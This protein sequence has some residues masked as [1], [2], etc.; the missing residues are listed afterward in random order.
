MIRK[1]GNKTNPI[2]YT[3]SVAL[4][5]FVLY[6]VYFNVVFFLFAIVVISCV[7]TRSSK[8]L[9]F[10]SL[11]FLCF[12]ILYFIWYLYI[13]FVALSR[14]YAVFP[15]DF[16][17][18][19]HV[20]VFSTHILLSLELFST[21]SFPHCVRIVGRYYLSFALVYYKIDAI[22]HKYGFIVF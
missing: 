6:S 12:F 14:L 10:A 17:V 21:V 9:F 15:L 1:K 11:R 7:L 20:P 3:K 13:W 2:H 19:M 8:K 18:F 5:V 22:I 4:C 16:P